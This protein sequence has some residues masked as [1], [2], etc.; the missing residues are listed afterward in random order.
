MM[1]FAIAYI[2]P[3]A[4]NL[5]LVLT[6]GTDYWQYEIID[7]L[8]V[9]FNGAI[10]MAIVDAMVMAL[11]FLVLWKLMKVDLIEKVK[12][13]IK[14]F[15][16]TAAIYLVNCNTLVSLATIYIIRYLQIILVSCII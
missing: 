2:G 10:L 15:G 4:E 7:D 3:N 5:V 14:T 16:P 13:T 6:F 11:T 1:A 8:L 12:K 9:Y